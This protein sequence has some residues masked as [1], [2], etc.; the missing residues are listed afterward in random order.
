[1]SYQ[2]ASTWAEDIQRAVA[3]RRMPP[4]KP[5]PGYGEFRDSYGLTEEERQTILSW[6]HAG[7]PEGDPGDL[8]E[9]VVSSGEWQLGEPDL[10]VEM[11]EPYTPPRG[12][13]TYRCFIVS[14]PSQETLYVNAFDVRPGDR[15]IVHHVI[16]YIDEKGLAERLDQRDEGPGYNCFGGPGFELSFSS[17]LGGWAPGTIARRLPEGIGIQ[18]P[19]GG[20]LIMQV[21]YYAAGR[22]SEDQTKVGLYLTKGP[23]ERRLFYIPVVNTRFEIPAGNSNY[24]VRANFMVPPLLDAKV[25]QVFPHMHLLGKK[26]QLDYVD[27]RRNTRPGILIDDWDFNW[28]GFY[29]YKEAIAVPAFTDIRLR[30]VFDNSANNPRNPSNPVR[31]V[32]WGEG[33]EDEM[34]LAFLG[35]TFDRENLL[36]F[37]GSQR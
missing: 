2:D 15:Q 17:M 23:V 30:C 35:V 21:H 31:N 3:E 5:V 14:N 12:K 33:T 34:C 18:I 11:K 29:T 36:P 4:W 32:G 13:D 16:L 28:Q 22:T 37:S 8:P 20:R 7:A 24:E 10:V 27:L 26:I 1:M 19:R 25:I 9:P 6:V